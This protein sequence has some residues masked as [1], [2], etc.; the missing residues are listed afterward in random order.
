MKRSILILGGAGFIGS[1]IAF[2]FVKAGDRVTVIDGFLPGTGGRI[3]NLQTVISNILFIH[4]RIE[5]TKGL[6]QLFQDVDVIVDCMAWT[7]HHGAMKDPL[8]DL[9]LNAE[10]HLHVLANI[11]KM[12][13]SRVIFLGSRSQYG[14]PANSE[15]T[16]DTQ[17]SPE[18]IQGIHKVTAESYYRVFAKSR[19]LNVVSLRLANCF[20]PN[21]PTQG[22]DIG[23][24]GG[25]IRDLLSGKSVEVFGRS[26]KRH[27]VYVEDV[28]EVVFRLSEKAFS[29]FAAFNL[30]G[31]T[32]TI[33]DLAGMLHQFVGTGSVSYTDMPKNVAD[34]DMGN[35]NFKDGCLRAYLG[36]FP[37]TDMQKALAET[38]DYFLKENTCRC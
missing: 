24:V 7:S 6:S 38:I 5:S 23:L 13:V 21:Q 3:D 19:G 18:D 17:M 26:R 32:I 29:G 25:F 1:R 12:S 30:A 15:I 16:E 11:A 22:T 35:A 37:K 10:S 20:G 34:I 14:S 27:L 28:A 4:S 2:R 9:K 31:Q 8:Y 36:Q 33:E